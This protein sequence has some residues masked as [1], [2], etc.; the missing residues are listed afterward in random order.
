MSLTASS[1]II[2]SKTERVDGSEEEMIEVSSENATFKAKSAM[3][4]VTTLNAV[5]QM[6]NRALSLCCRIQRN[7]ELFLHQ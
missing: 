6:F 1:S 7:L 4:N 5:G 2:S 3:I